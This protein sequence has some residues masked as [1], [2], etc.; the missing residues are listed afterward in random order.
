VAS[1]NLQV[2]IKGQT[3][4]GGD[5]DK[6][7]RLLKIINRHG[8]EVPEVS[9]LSKLGDEEIEIKGKK[10]GTIHYE[11]KDEIRTKIFS[12]FRD[13]DALIVADNELILRDLTTYSFNDRF[14]AMR[15]RYVPFEF[16]NGVKRTL[17]AL[18][19]RYY[20]DEDGDGSFEVMYDTLRMP[21]VIPEWAI[22]K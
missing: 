18:I 9:L 19:T 4:N 10:V 21:P 11:A 16:A 7:V 5:S 8:W 13:G 14:F 20:I 22:K 2:G 6:P 17:G 3:R 1:L 15:V 12:Y